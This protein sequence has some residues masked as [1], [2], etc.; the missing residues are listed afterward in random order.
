MAVVWT[1]AF[2]AK[3]NQPCQSTML[4]RG[5][6]FHRPSGFAN[7]PRQSTALSASTLRNP[8]APARTHR[9][10]LAA[11]FL[12]E[13]KSTLPKAYALK[14]ARMK[15]RA[16][17]THARELRV[18]E[19]EN[20]TLRVTSFRWPWMANLKD[21]GEAKDRKSDRVGSARRKSKIA[22]FA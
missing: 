11:P 1:A 13:A 4:T 7:R 20:H 17:G 3:P 12:A 10:L 19:G 8:Y 22:L 14:S 2:L 6:G 9:R 21:Q 16:G 15:P 18:E 5:R